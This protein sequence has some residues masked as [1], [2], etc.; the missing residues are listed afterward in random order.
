MKKILLIVFCS[1]V[2]IS[3]ET[4]MA[5][6]DYNTFAIKVLSWGSGYRTNIDIPPVLKEGDLITFTMQSNAGPGFISSGQ[7]EWTHGLKCKNRGMYII[8][9]LG[10]PE[11]FKPSPDV[12]LVYAEPV[13]PVTQVVHMYNGLIG[14]SVA[15]PTS[16]SCEQYAEWTKSTRNYYGTGK[17]V[18]A[19]YRVVNLGSPGAFSWSMP[20]ETYFTRRDTE[21]DWVDMGSLSGVANKGNYI[22]SG[23]IR[24]WCK[25]QTKQ[26]LLDYKTITPD[27]VKDNEVNS[28]LTLECGGGGVG[29]AKITLSNHSDKSIV[30]LGN[31]VES[32]ISLSESKVDIPKDNSVDIVVSSRLITGSEEIKA[33]AFEGSEVITVEWL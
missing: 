10:F 24:G 6:N 3:P 30:N 15:T 22:F 4:V 9:V 28:K 12:E 2:F 29:S 5:Y 23:T 33:G 13:G 16:N 21:A 8:D 20:V 11:S 27:L 26:V 19:K 14:V 18:G 31:G 32:E 1:F 17:V 25:V 7:L